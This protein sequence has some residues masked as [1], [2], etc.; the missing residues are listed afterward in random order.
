MILLTGAARQLGAAVVRQLLARTDASEIA[1]LPADAGTADPIGAPWRS[2]ASGT[3][4]PRPG[5]SSSR[6]SATAGSTRW[7]ASSLWGWWRRWPRG[8]VPS[9]RRS[10]RSSIRCWPAARWCLSRLRRLRWTL[11]TS[12]RRSRRLASRQG[13][14]VCCRAALR[15]ASTSSA[16]P[17]WT[18]SSSPEAPRPDG[19]SARSAAPRCGGW[20]WSWAGSQPRSCSTTPI[21]PSP[22]RGSAPAR[23]SSAIRSRSCSRVISANSR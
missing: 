11:S 19:G 13:C 22:C 16:T 17:A 6:S 23:S 4:A 1:L 9:C 8:T 2:A 14:S 18:P 5:R 21:S 7:S 12:R 15:S 20:C 3:P 10:T